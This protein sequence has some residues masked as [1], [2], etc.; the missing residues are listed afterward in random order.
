MNLNESMQKIQFT[1][2]VQLLLTGIIIDVNSVNIDIK[3]LVGRA[4]SLFR[5]KE[6][7]SYSNMIMVLFIP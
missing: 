2:S 7:L 4:E 3:S 1:N 5:I 6:V